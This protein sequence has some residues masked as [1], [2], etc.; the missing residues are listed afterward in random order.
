MPYELF[1]FLHLVSVIL[2]IAFTFSAF[3]NPSSSRRKLVLALAGSASLLVLITGLGMG[4]I[5]NFP[6][7]FFAKLIIWLAISA[8]A[9]VAFRRKALNGPL[10]VI[11]AVLVV[12]AT[13]LAVF[14]PF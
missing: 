8:F 7:W 9:G 3:A 4:H 13:W 2:L 6:G 11:T 14:K 10:S 5:F 1:K 12:L